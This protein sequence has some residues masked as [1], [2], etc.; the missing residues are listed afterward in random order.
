MLRARGRIRSLEGASTI[1]TKEKNIMLSNRRRFLQGAA[2]TAGLWSHAASAKVAPVTLKDRNYEPLKLPRPISLA[3][4]T[5]LDVSPANQVLCAAK[6]GYSHVGIRLVPATPTETQ[7]DMIG[8]TPMIR[9]VEANLKATGVKV[10]DIEILRIKPDTRAVNWKAFFETGARLGATQVLCAGNDPDINRLTDNYAE[11][12]E[13]AH[14]YGL[15]LSIEPM[16][17]CNVSTVKQQGEILRKINRPNAG[18]LVDPIHFYRAKND[19]KDIDNLPAG[20]LKYCQMCD[21]TAEMPDTMDGILYQARNFR[22]SP[23]TGAADLVQLLKHLPNLPISIEACNANLALTMSPL[24]RARM[25][26]EDMVAVLNA[27]GEH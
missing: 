3:A 15:N 10:L 18:C 6:A 13:L 25:Y 20:S 27:A 21:I 19:Y 9:E 16:P 5:V 8:D 2:A 14:P 22:L 12:C 26:L 11:L 17:W 23:S 1:S 7:Y 4:L 24:D